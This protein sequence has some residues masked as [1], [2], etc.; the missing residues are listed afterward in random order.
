MK[1]I[2]C[3]I[4]VAVMCLTAAGCMEKEEKP[5]N[6]GPEAAQMR[7]I[8]ELATM[9]CYYHNVAKYNRESATGMLFWA[10][11]RKFWIEYAGV[12]TVGIDVSK[13]K[14]DIDGEA[15]KITIPKAKVLGCKVD[16]ETFNKD[17]FIMA[18]DSAKIEA[19]HQTEAFKDAQK[20]MKK[21]AAADTT[22]MAAAQQQAQKLIE[23]YV[24]N[25]SKHTDK[26]YKIQWIYLEKA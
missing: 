21:A 11:D 1:K 19:E 15:V 5:E 25:I 20:N 2:I 16:E 3:L 26:E 14:I 13:V 18:K 22:L 4:L 7:A 9:K 12:V 6:L 23:D 8:C 17:A 10:R 24:K